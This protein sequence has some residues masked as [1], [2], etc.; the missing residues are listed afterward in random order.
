MVLE[1]KFGNQGVD[2]PGKR[3]LVCVV[4]TYYRLFARAFFFFLILSCFFQNLF[5]FV[6][7]CHR[8][9]YLLRIDLRLLFIMLG[10]IRVYF[11]LANKIIL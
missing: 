8:T 2:N 9:W 1:A 5:K 4:R 7:L 11:Q 6:V 3:Q 10:A